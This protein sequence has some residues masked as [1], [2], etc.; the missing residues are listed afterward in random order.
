MACSASAAD[1]D[2][3]LEIDDYLGYAPIE[4]A[5]HVGTRIRELNESCVSASFCDHFETLARVEAADPAQARVATFSISSGKK[6][7]EFKIS[8]EDWEKNHGNLVRSHIARLNSFGF[9]VTPQAILKTTYQLQ[10]GDGADSARVAVDAREV[11]LFATN[12]NGNNLN[13]KLIVTREWTGLGQLLLREEGRS[14]MIS[15]VERHR[16]LQYQ[17]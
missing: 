3:L 2:P 11:R 13:I 8:A 6:T 14:G 17:N 16:V 7:S 10:L 15:G 12:G 4:Q 5:F 1:L 9:Q